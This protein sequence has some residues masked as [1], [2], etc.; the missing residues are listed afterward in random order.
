MWNV[1]LT[2]RDPDLE[3]QFWAAPDTKKNLCTIDKLALVAV[4]VNN[5]SF[6]YMYYHTG[7]APNFWFY[8]GSCIIFM[9]SQCAAFVYQISDPDRYYRHRIRIIVA[10]RLYRAVICLI[11]AIV[12]EHD[13]FATQS[14]VQWGD[15]PPS[16]WQLIRPLFVRTGLLYAFMF[17]F[18]FPTK[19]VLQLP[20]HT[21]LLPGFYYS[22]RTVN[23]I[24]ESP[25][26][27]DVSSFVYGRFE[28]LLPASDVFMRAEEAWERCSPLAGQ[29]LVS[30]V[31]EAAVLCAMLISVN[32]FKQLHLQGATATLTAECFLCRQCDAP[33]TARCTCF[34]VAVL[35][36][37]AIDFRC[38]MLPQASLYVGYATPLMLSCILE[39]RAK[40][41][42]LAQHRPSDDPV[43]RLQLTE[44]I[45]YRVSAFVTWV[46]VYVLLMLF[47]ANVVLLVIQQF[48]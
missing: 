21:A 20:L 4:L 11:T 41:L 29:V 2:F 26:F 44:P 33:I 31:R 30:T 48:S 7:N 28:W 36:L 15:H 18:T 3:T 19:F 42:F 1:F 47:T 6:I 12:M 9:L 46:Y 5:I 34:Q 45:L 25:E 38:R 16:A 14:M 32:S 40:R 35:N 17:M 39:V 43:V 23:R 37:C 22:I 10:Q 27:R 24:L 8:T 13:P